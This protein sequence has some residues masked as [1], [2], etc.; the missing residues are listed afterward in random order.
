M[1]LKCNLDLHQKKWRNPVIETYWLLYWGRKKSHNSC[2][3]KIFPNGKALITGNARSNCYHYCGAPKSLRQVHD[4]YYWDKNTSKISC[5]QVVGLSPC[6]VTVTTRIST[7]L[8]GDPY[9]P[10][11]ATVT[12]RGDNPNNLK[13][14]TT[15][16]LIIMNKRQIILCCCHKVLAT[17]T[18]L[19]SNQ[20][21]IIYL[22][23]KNKWHCVLSIFAK[24]FCLKLYCDMVIY[25]WFTLICHRSLSPFCLAMAQFTCPN[26][27]I[28]CF[29]SPKSIT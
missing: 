20:R 21:N 23:A 24:W 3:A 27:H 5:E 9:K 8:V 16:N 6:P 1:G 11:F 26:P 10:S 15:D 4:R 19:Y 28:V 2:D 29:V 18:A 14:C 22:I 13:H 12:G 7:F 25:H 17:S